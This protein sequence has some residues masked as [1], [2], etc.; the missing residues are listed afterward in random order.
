MKIA[1]CNQHGYWGG[2]NNDGGSLTILKS[3]DALRK[4]GHHVHIVTCSDRHTWIKHPKVIKKI[5]YDTDACIAVSASAVK[6][7][8]QSMPSYAKPFWWMRG[9]EK[10][11]MPKEQILKWA[12]NIKVIVNASHLQRWLEKHDI[13]SPAPQL[14]YAGLDLDHWKDFGRRKLNGKTTIG[15]LYNTHHAT[16]RWKDFRLLATRLG[17]KLYKYVACGAED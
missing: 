12:S 6:P 7:M 3:A 8:L 9:I 15:C 10:W 17:N 2:L 16:K 13:I 5:P 11:Q 14:C 1:F 4:L